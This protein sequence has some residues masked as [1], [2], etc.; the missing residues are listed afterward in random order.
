MFDENYYQIEI[1]LKPTNVSSSSSILTAEDVW[2]PEFNS[3]D[4]DLQKLIDMK[5]KLISNKTLN[6][7]A[8]YFDFDLNEIEEFLPYSQLPG[9]KKYKFSIKGNPSL[10]RVSTLVL[11]LK[12]PSTQ[13]GRD[14]S[15]EVWFNE[16]RLSNI[17]SSGGW[18]T[19]ASIDANIADFANISFN[20]KFFICWV[21]IN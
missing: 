11:G 8:T 10:G 9:E 20:N 16:L 12:N 15:A 18:S 5:L 1:P 7:E 19:V 14:L 13:V 6:N 2:I 17:K 3:I 4:L 21:W